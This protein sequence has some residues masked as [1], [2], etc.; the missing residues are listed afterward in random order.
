[1]RTLIIVDAPNAF[2]AEGKR[3]VPNHQ[4]GLEAIGRHVEG[5]GAGSL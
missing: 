3:P 2:A 1:M 4:K 5:L